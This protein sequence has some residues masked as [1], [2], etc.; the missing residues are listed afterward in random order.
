MR[1]LCLAWRLGH[2]LGGHLYS[3]MCICELIYVSAINCAHWTKETSVN[4]TNKSPNHNAERSSFLMSNALLQLLYFYFY[5]FFLCLQPLRS[6]QRLT[7][8]QITMAKR[9]L[10]FGCCRFLHCPCASCASHAAATAIAVCACA[11]VHLYTWSKDIYS[12]FFSML[13][14]GLLM[15]VELFW[16]LIKT[17]NWH[18]IYDSRSLAHALTLVCCLPFWVALPCN[19]SML[20]PRLLSNGKKSN[21]SIALLLSLSLAL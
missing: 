10:V 13:Q 7:A 21:N 6:G 1:L 2:A 16:Y 9:H 12:C 8:W 3:S 5:F 15:C 20:P 19:F 17:Q 4:G 18:Q 14:V 11:C